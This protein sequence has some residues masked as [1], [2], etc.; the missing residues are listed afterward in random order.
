M[1]RGFIIIVIFFSVL[2]C[3]N[4]VWA[5]TNERPMRGEV[6]RFVYE[7][8]KK[9]HMLTPYWYISIYGSDLSKKNSVVFT[10]SEC[11]SSLIKDHQLRNRDNKENCKRSYN[12]P[13]ELTSRSENGRVTKSPSSGLIKTSIQKIRGNY[14]YVLFDIKGDF[15]NED[16]HPSTESLEL[17]VLVKFDLRKPHYIKLFDKQV[18]LEAGLSPEHYDK[19]YKS[20]AESED[21]RANTIKN[22]NP[23]NDN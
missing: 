20:S 6:A 15:V 21:P 14:L 4:I 1:Q 7:K 13:L 16:V 11:G 19:L 18:L 5:Q 2:V 23:N 10:I 9:E 12:I 3:T 17:S 8:P 22:N